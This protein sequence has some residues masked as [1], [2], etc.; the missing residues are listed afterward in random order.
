MAS[1]WKFNTSLLEIWDFRVRLENLI[2]RALVGAVIGIGGG[3]PLSI[4]LGISPSST[5]N[6]SL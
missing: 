6:S 3:L 5:P 1:Y 4:G 2:K